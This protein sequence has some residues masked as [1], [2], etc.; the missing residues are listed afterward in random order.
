MKN[1]RWLRRVVAAL[2]IAAGTGAHAETKLLLSTFFPTTHPI[3]AQV[4]APWAKDIET[5]TQG[6]VKVEFATSSL[7]PPPG[8][9]DMVQRGIADVALQYTG[10]VPNR[11]QPELLTELP[12]AVGT[13]AQMSKALWATHERFLGKDD[14]RYKGVHLLSLIV[15]PPQEFFCV[16]ACP[17]GIEQIRASKIAATPGT[18]A[19]QYGALTNGVVAGPASRYFEIV[20]KGIV[21]A[22]TAVTPIDA[23]SFNLAPSTTGMLRTR[24]LGTA[25]AFALVVNPRKWSG[26][27]APDRAAI[28]RLSG[29]AFGARMAALDEANAASLKK[30]AEGGVKLQD[31]G[32]QLN[33]DLQKAYAF[34][35]DEWKL[36]AGKR[37]IDAAAALRFYRQQL[38][39]DGGAATAETRK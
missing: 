32:A 31:A 35:D 37:G 17:T 27:E 19:R 11:L 20:S 24:N 8:Q 1:N 39:A 9:L 30:L 28:E 3:Y 2:A 12:G 4:L 38:H 5:N 10:L 33:A 26:L 16:K 13:S 6:R 25:G 18:S 22:Y 34:L 29:A 15:F 36:E 23:L 14:S 21:D 7:A